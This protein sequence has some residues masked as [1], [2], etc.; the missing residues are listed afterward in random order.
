VNRAGPVFLKGKPGTARGAR[1]LEAGWV[2]RAGV[3]RATR[4]R[5]VQAGPRRGAGN[6]LRYVHTGQRGCL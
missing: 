6:R 3:T 2:W 5:R 4:A 1:N